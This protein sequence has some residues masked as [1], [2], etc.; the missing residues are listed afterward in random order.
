MG[1]SHWNLRKICNQKNIAGLFYS[2]SLIMLM[3]EASIGLL[4]N[5]VYAINICSTAL[6]V[7]SMIVFCISTNDR[8]RKKD[9]S[10]GSEIIYFQLNVECPD[11]HND[12]EYKLMQTKEM[13]HKWTHCIKMEMELMDTNNHKIRVMN[14]KNPNFQTFTVC[15]VLLD[16]DSYG[17]SLI[18]ACVDNQCI[19]NRIKQ[20]FELES[21]P[22]LS[23]IANE[24]EEPIEAHS[25]LSR[26]FLDNPVNA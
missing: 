1:L 8:Q 19:S 18:E 12:D 2:Y 26:H 16:I 13:R 4:C 7:I 17:I 3:I 14:S 20:E 24:F 6:T 5:G 15:G 11:H 25:R 23:F 9:N 22:E 10:D 21:V